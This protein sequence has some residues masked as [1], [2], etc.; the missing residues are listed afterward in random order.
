MKYKKTSEILSFL[1]LLVSYLVLS[2]CVETENAI[3]PVSLKNWEIYNTENGLG[4]DSVRTLF[5]DKEGN[6]WVG[7]WNKG[8]CKFDGKMWTTYNVSSGLIDNSV[9]S[10]AQD[11]YDRMWFGTD[12]GL[13]IFSDNK[14]TNINDYGSI[15]SILKD[16]DDNMWWSTSN[17]GILEFNNKN[18]Y[19]HYD[20]LCARC[21]LVNIV[22]EDSERNIWFGSERDLKKLTGQTITSYNQSDGL[23]GGLM[24]IIS[25]DQDIW[26]NIWIGT[27]MTGSVARYNSGKFELVS[28]LTGSSINEV[29]SIASDNNGNVWFGLWGEQIM[30]FNGSV[31]KSYTVKDGIP[32]INVTKILKDKHGYLWFGTQA[33]GVAKYLPGLD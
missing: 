11:G 8:V 6:I 12:G 3:D 5:E 24:G 22:F 27:D 26:G 14:W 31:M 4:S 7:T 18:I 15:S 13:S 9:L 10:I 25:M 28:L 30:K 16:Y 2:G 33:S 23:P 29:T 32:G 21:N 17:Y 20:T 19:Q 1:I